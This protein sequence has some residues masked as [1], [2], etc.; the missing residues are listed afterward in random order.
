LKTKSPSE[1]AE[2]SSIK[3]LEDKK[4]FEYYES[5][6]NESLEDKTPSEGRKMSSRGL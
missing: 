4:S 6:F 2:V 1:T 3:A 5:V